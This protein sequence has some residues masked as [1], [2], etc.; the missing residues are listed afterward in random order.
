MQKRVIGAFIIFIS[1]I[2]LSGFISAACTLRQNTTC[3]PQE[4]RV[5]G[6]TSSTNAHGQL[7]NQS[8]YLYSLCCGNK[9]TT[10]DVINPLTGQPR[11]KIIGLSAQTNAHA[12][13]PTGGTYT[14]NVC[15]GSFECI[16]TTG[17]CLSPYDENPLLSLSATTNAHIGNFSDYSIKICCKGSSAFIGPTCNLTDATW[18]A[19]APISEGLPAIMTVAGVGCFEQGGGTTVNFSVYKEVSGPDT[20]ISLIV[21]DYPQGEW[22]SVIGT[23]YYFNA[24]ASQSNDTFSS[25]SGTGNDRLTVVQQTN[26]NPCGTILTC[27]SYTSYGT[28]ADS[29]AACNTDVCNVDQDSGIDSNPPPGYTFGCAWNNSIGTCNLSEDYG[30]VPNATILCEN[31]QTLCYNPNSHLKYCYVGYSCPTGHQVLSNGNG[32]CDLGEGCSSV[33]CLEN[34]Q[35]SCV[36]GTKCKKGANIN[37]GMCYSTGA[38]ANDTACESGYT[39]CRSTSLNLQYC[40]P[41]G[42][43]P[44]GSVAALHSCANGSASPN[45]SLTC[46]GTNAVCQNNTCSDPTMAVGK[47]SKSYINTGDT[48]ED[49]NFLTYSWTATWTGTGTRPANCAPTG[50]ASIECPAQIPLPL[51]TPVNAIITV[52]TIIGIYALMNLIKKGHKKHHRRKN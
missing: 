17:S 31:G 16:N 19:D 18:Q 12:E 14:N 43:C 32:L 28:P 38:Q 45:P 21:S 10:C 9:T 27:E 41:E 47:C 25:L 7:A 2:L 34:N 48:C 37:E 6:L 26:P 46:I 1:L 33:E 24:T 44:T 11:N 30:G 40:Y 49:D 51:F 4:T 20:F 23:N 42:N 3:N 35:D 50:S 15:Y 8:G 5:M 36:P 22:P 39:L 13:I 29:K 52:L